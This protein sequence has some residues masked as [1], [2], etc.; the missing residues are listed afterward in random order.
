M[1]TSEPCPRP[2]TRGDAAAVIGILAVLEGQILGSHIEPGVV[3]RFRRRLTD[4][5]LLPG[6]EESDVPAALEE[7]NQ[8]IRFALGEYD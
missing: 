6:G 3:D 4:D 8:R 2:L 1:E 5:G 7:L